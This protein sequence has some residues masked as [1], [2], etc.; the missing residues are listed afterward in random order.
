[1]HN[2]YWVFFFC[3]RLS[4]ACRKKAKIVE[5]PISLSVKPPCFW[6]FFAQFFLRI[7]RLTFFF[8]QEDSHKLGPKNP[9]VSFLKPYKLTFFWYSGCKYKE[10]GGTRFWGGGWG[11]NDLCGVHFVNF[12][13]WLTKK[14]WYMRYYF[15]FTNVWDIQSTY[16]SLQRG[17]GG[18][19]SPNPIFLGY[20][21]IICSA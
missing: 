1:M 20:F 19:I 5:E 18:G 14:E 15:K 16:T 21:L 10:G 13:D 6:S 3:G 12:F 4:V 11:V 17:G 9:L 2:E 7:W 8:W